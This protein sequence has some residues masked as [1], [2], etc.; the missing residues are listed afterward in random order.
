MAAKMQPGISV[1]PEVWK[2]FKEKYDKQASKQIEQFMRMAIENDRIDTISTDGINSIALSDPS[3]W[4]IS[5]S[6]SH[7]NVSYSCANDISYSTTTPGVI[8][9]W[10]QQADITNEGSNK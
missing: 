9:S 7:I 3:S 6:S 8:M 1:D 5:Y 10:K 2:K 4:N